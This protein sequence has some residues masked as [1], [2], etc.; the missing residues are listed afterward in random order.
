LRTAVGVLTFT[1][2]VHDSAGLGIAAREAN[3]A[4]A[5]AARAAP[6]GLGAL[7]VDDIVTTGATVRACVRALESA[8]WPVVGAAVV[9][10]TPRRSAG[11]SGPLAEHSQPV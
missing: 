2:R 11:V 1:R 6:A 8:G 7:V 10:A 9:A 4:G 3:L 5:I